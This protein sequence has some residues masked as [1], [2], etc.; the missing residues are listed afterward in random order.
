M[1]VLSFIVT[2]MA[3]ARA[4][5]SLERDEELERQPVAG[6]VVQPARFF[7]D[8]PAA[9]PRVAV[10]VP[11]EVLLIQIDRHVRLEQAAAESFLLTPTP[12]TLHTSTISPLVH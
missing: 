5:R 2:M 11:I 4:I 8:A 6:P 3:L 9:P 7:V 10:P 12:E 1:S